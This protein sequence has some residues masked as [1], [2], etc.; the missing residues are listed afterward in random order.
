[1]KISIRSS[2]LLLFLLC[3]LPATASAGSQWRCQ[4]TGEVIWFQD[5][6]QLTAE[7]GGRHFIGKW[8]S[9]GQYSCRFQLQD[10]YAN[11]SGVVSFRLETNNTAIATPVS[12]GASTRWSRLGGR[13]AESSETEDDGTG[14]FM[15]R[16]SV[17]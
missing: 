13:G 3:L 5:G 2:L 15:P 8:W 1:M 11:Y 14:W 10:I 6:G 7:G 4:S 17:F 12:G 16:K 9:T